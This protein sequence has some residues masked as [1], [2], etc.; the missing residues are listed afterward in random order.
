MTAM[1]IQ[2]RNNAYNRRTTLLVGAAA[3]VAG[4]GMGGTAGCTPDTAVQTITDLI[5]KIQAG[6]VTGLATACGIANKYVPTADTVLSVLEAYLA[7]TLT[8][9]N[10]AAGVAIA[11]KV[12]DSIVAMGCPPSPAAPTAMGHAVKVNGKDVPVVF[13]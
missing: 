6:V 2:P 10:L 8:T 3:A 4:M 5:N 7:T 12:I 13:Y 11:Q 1:P 9:A